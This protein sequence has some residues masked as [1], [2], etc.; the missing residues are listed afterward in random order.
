MINDSVGLSASLMAG[1]TLSDPIRLVNAPAGFDP[2]SQG[3]CFSL[4]SFQRSN[5]A[6]SFAARASVM[7]IA[8]ELDQ[9]DPLRIREI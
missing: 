7:P 2:L 3:C 1:G 8:D 4:A 9:V 6:C 5:G